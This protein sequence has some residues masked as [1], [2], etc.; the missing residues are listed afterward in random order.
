MS[1]TSHF[2]FHGWNNKGAV[3]GEYGNGSVKQIIWNG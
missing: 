3:E 1:G 2:N